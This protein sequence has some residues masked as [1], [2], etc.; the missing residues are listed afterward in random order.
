[1]EELIRHREKSSNGILERTDLACC[2][3]HV[4]A[5][6]AESLRHHSSQ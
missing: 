4:Q 6:V 3:G 2:V 1:V 5:F